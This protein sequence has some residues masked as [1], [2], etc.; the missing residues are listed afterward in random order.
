MNPPTEQLIRDYL[1]RVSVAALGRLSS[2]ERREFLTRTRE[3]LERESRYPSG[4]DPTAV[5]RLLDGLGRPEALVELERARLSLTR[6][7]SALGAERLRRLLSRPAA[8]LASRPARHPAEPPPP[9]PE[10]DLISRMPLTGAESFDICC[11]P[12][13]AFP[14]P[15]R[16]E[17][18][19][20]TGEV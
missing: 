6:D 15:L 2:E 20:D 16:D 8:W 14:A 4:A 5:E 18:L 3:E 9:P 11:L 10:P 17:I 12:V 1:N 7:G 19:P 13:R